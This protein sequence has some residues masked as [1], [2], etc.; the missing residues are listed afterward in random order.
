MTDQQR[1]TKLER[2]YAQLLAHFA[3]LQRAVLKSQDDIIQLRGIQLQRP[4]SDNP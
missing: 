3:I 4:R 1:I 2:D